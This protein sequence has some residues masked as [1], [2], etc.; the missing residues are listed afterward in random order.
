MVFCLKHFRD[1]GINF[2]AGRC[3]VLLSL[4]AGLLCRTTKTLRDS[5]YL[6]EGVFITK[7]IDRV[8]WGGAHLF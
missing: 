8:H 3:L 5:G 6:V 2:F 4:D 7:K 1:R